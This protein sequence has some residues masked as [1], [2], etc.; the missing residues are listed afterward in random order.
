MVKII[1]SVI[2]DVANNQCNRLF[3]YLIPSHLEA[4]VK[5]GSRVFVPFGARRVMGFVVKTNVESTYDKPLKE[6]I[7]LIDY[8]PVLS[9]EFIDLGLSLSENYFSFLIDNYLMMIPSALKTKYPKMVEFLELDALS[10][11]LKAKI[12]GETI[13]PLESL[14]DYTKEIASLKKQ[15]KVKVSN[16]FK[17]KGR[18]KSVKYVSL[19]DASLAKTEKQREIVSYLCENTSKVLLTN[20][21]NDMG[22][23]KAIINTMEKNKVLEIIDEET[24]RSVKYNEVEAVKVKLNSY[25]QNAYDKIRESLGTFNE[26]LIHGVCGSGKTEVYLN[27]IEEALKQGKSALMLVPEISL[28]SQISSRFKARFGDKVAILHSR[29]TIGEKFDEWRRIKRGEA[30]IVV[31]A[32]SALFA[33]VNNLGII[34][35]DEEQ[36]ASYIQDSSPKYNSHFVARF[37]CSYNNIPLVLGSATPSVRTYYKAKQNQ[38]KLLE[39]PVRANNTMPKP[40]AIIDMRQELRENNKS[41]LSRTLQFE[42]RKTLDKNEQAILLINRR[43]YSTFVMCRSCGKEIKCPHCDVSLT[44]HKYDNQLTCHYCGFKISVPQKCPQCSSPYIR[45][46]GDGTQKVEE[47][48]KK[49]FPEVGIIRMDSDTTTSKNSHNDI[50]ASFQ[51]HQAD[52]LLGTQVVAKGLDFPLVRLVGIVNADL[53]LKMPFFDARERSFDLLEQASGRAGRKDTDNVVLIQTY[54]PDDDIIKAASLHD[55]NYFYETEIKK[56]RL[57]N[58]VPFKEVI[59]VTLSSLNE[60]QASQEA[61]SI[62]SLLKKKLTNA[63]I[64]GPVKNYIYKINDRYYYLITIKCEISDTA[65]V[66][67]YL[68][69]RYQ[70]NQDINLSITRM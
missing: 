55:Y 9:Q 28:S 13:V 1:V 67:N 17:E 22:Y 36:E 69:E 49:L 39:I 2:V 70:T 15:G 44:Y 48:L 20:L 24:Y 11:E 3:D 66:L 41:V 29:L 21:V 6:I 62:A 61:Y 51:N 8:E 68:N 34:I 52:I 40:A 25:Q 54:A 12:K 5:I 59:E 45:Y 10:L 35:M 65:E 27:L 53:G 46:V 31:G 63:V 4:F 38:I 37:R 50:I 33:P 16:L 43:G 32:R 57:L 18:I 42:L 58:V 47:E 7:E 23:S 56:R 14:S 30:S 60:L 64:L 19:L 26:F